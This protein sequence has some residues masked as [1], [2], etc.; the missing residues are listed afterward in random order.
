MRQISDGSRVKAP[1]QD[2]IYLVDRGRIRWI[3]DAD[4]YMGIFRNW[5]GILAVD[6]QSYPIGPPLV[7]GTMLFKYPD[8]PNVYLY[9]KEDG[10]R[11]VKRF[12]TSSDAFNRYHFGWNK[13]NTIGR[14]F[15][16]PFGSNIGRGL[17]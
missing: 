13:I 4:V 17:S 6:L 5:D 9:D 12:I 7:R 1:F 2:P 14:T 8:S 11:W 15:N 3:V 10:Y 16:P